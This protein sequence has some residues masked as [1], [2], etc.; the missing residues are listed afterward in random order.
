LTG[1]TIERTPDEA[2]T[3]DLLMCG[4]GQWGG[5]GNNSYS[6]AQVSPVRVKALS[7]LSE[8]GFDIYYFAVR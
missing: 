7:G 8:C 5:L 3:V 2:A 1:F 4:D 6:N